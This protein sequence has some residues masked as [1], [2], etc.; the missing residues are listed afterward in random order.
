M[1][2]ALLGAT[3][4]IGRS[5]LALCDARDLLVV[6][7]TQDPTTAATALATY[8]ITP[9]R[10]LQ[11]YEE[12][13][14]EAFDV[15]INATGIGSPIQ[16]A[17]APE[18]VFTVTESMDELILAYAKQYP[19][20]RIFNISSGAVYGTAAGA[21]VSDTANARFAINTLLPK[22]AY[23]ISK[24]AS[25]AKHRAYQEYAIVDLRTFAF[26][27][28][29][30]SLDE[31]FFLSQVA[32]AILKGETFITRSDSM[33]RDCVSPR[34]L[35]EII[36]FLANE[37]SRNDVFDVVSKAPFEKFELLSVLQERFGLKWSTEASVSSSSPTGEKNVYAS[38]SKK[39]E[40]SGFT[41]NATATEEIIS[42]LEALCA[43]TSLR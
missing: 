15:I 29:F 30:L 23:A 36:L 14:N 32:N 24:L 5:L 4:Y 18:S 8:D 9:K 35:L 37:K 11:T 34:G 20:T 21:L 28:R 40:Q 42:E 31:P 33:V 38:S 13:R 22:D 16:L 1:R 3:G 6:P 39:L 2:I 10:Q 43:T 27:S 19:E 7:F 25:E 26:F 12:L 41:P 17:K